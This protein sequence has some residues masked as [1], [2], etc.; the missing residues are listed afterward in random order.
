MRAGMRDP[1]GCQDGSGFGAGLYRHIGIR[2]NPA[3]YIIGQKITKAGFF[4]VDW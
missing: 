2:L 1:D 4:A 3:Y